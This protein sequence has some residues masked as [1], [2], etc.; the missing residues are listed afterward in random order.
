MKSNYAKQ[1]GKTFKEARSK[2]R[3]K[4]IDVA[5]KAGIN[6]NY[7]AKVERGEVNVS[8]ELG[9]KIANVLKIKLN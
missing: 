5:D 1:L 2:M 8:M 3:L 4:Q 7:Y 6:S 9:S